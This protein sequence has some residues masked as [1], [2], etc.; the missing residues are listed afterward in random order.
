LLS[1][2]LNFYLDENPLNHTFKDQISSL[3]IKFNN[4]EKNSSPTDM[5]YTFVFETILNIFTNLRCLKFDSSSDFAANVWMGIVTP[6]FVSTLLELHVN[7]PAMH[8]F[9]HLLD[10][11]FDQLRILY[12]NVNC[13]SSRNLDIDKYKVDFYINILFV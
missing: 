6:I 3:F 7:L 4:N 10:G 9:L 5:F 2:T 8:D 13:I 12:V 11:R 1:L